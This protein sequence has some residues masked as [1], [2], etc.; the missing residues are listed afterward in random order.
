M[1]KGASRDTDV[2]GRFGGEEFIVILPKSDEAGA[3]IFSERF[4]KRVEGTPVEFEGQPISITISI[5]TATFNESLLKQHN[6]EDCMKE[7]IARADAA[8]Y[9]AKSRG[10]NQ[11]HS[12]EALPPEAVA[13]L[14]V[15][16]SKG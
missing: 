3:R 14:A 16:K 10:R 15:E 5:G 6:P 8:L 1:L 4:R 7:L 11:T 2:A 9:F 12:F 13:Q